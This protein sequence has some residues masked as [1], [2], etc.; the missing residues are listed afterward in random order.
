MVF[1]YRYSPLSASD[2]RV[3]NKVDGGGIGVADG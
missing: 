1:L 3:S 2:K